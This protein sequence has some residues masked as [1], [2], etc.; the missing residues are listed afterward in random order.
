MGTIYRLIAFVAA[1]LCCL[2]I[3]PGWLQAQEAAPWKAESIAMS[4]D[5]R[6][7]TV[8]FVTDV[9]K[10]SLNYVREV[11]KY[12]LDNDLSSPLFL[13]DLE[14][15]ISIMSFSSDN[16]KIAVADGIRLTI[17]DTDNNS[18]LLDIP[19]PSAEESARFEI[20]SFSSDNR[21]I[22]T[23][24]YV[25]RTRHGEISIWDIETG[26]RVQSIPTDRSS[27]T[28]RRPW[29][30]PDWRLYLD[31]SR[32][33]QVSIYE[34]SIDKGV[35]SHLGTF[36][37]TARGAAFSSD[38]SLFALAASEGEIHV[39]RTDTWELTYIQVRGEHSCGGEYVSLAFGHNNPWLVCY[40]NGWLLVWD[41]GT[42]ELLLR[43]KP[44][45]GGF[46][47]ISV[48]DGILFADRLIYT[49]FRD[50]YTITVWDANNAF[51]KSTYPGFLPLLHPKGELMANISP[52]QRVLLWNVK[53]KQMVTI[54][55]LP[56]HQSL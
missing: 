30:S 9:K 51:E 38:S 12:S 31:W 56:E 2:A 22:M 46:S 40:G 3:S 52:D 18:L 43:D 29:L 41:I 32:S 19:V 35:G 44:D 48:D 21:Y 17:Y 47:H 27:E 45:D 5:G 4:P 11:W 13:R 42:G 23:F 7:L 33:D 15:Y 16:Q 34:F 26:M 6:Y 54:F 39:F 28:I 37:V 53:S 25:W 10:D 14:D 20:H 49:G 50:D 55:P 8:Q 1:F 24:S 36:A